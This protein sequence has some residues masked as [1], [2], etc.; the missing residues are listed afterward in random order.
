MTNEEGRAAIEATLN[1]GVRWA[2]N[3][4]VELLGNFSMSIDD[5]RRRHLREASRHL[6]EFLHAPRSKP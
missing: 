2:S 6:Q 4:L 1:N 3:I 5:E